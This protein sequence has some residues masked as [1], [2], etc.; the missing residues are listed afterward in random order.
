MAPACQKAP[1]PAPSKFIQFATF[2][3]V[4]DSNNGYQLVLTTYEA[5]AEDLPGQRFD[6]WVRVI[7]S[8]LERVEEFLRNESARNRW[9]ENI[10]HH[11]VGILEH[12][13]W[14]NCTVLTPPPSDFVVVPEAQFLDALGKIHR[15]ILQN[16]QR[17][18]HG[19]LMRHFLEQFSGNAGRR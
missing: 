3:E 17:P 5:R 7:S 19:V 10:K 18:E 4:Q 14:F 16:E 11:Q 13:I 15:L 8:T 2:N 6:L 9:H 1:Q 12:R